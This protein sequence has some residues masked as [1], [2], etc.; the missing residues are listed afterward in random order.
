MKI[1][2]FNGLF[3]LCWVLMSC[4]AGSDQSPTATTSEGAKG[5]QTSSVTDDTQKVVQGMDQVGSAGLLELDESGNIMPSA[6]PTL[7]S[8]SMSTEGLKEEPGPVSGIMLD[9]KGRFD[10]ILMVPEGSDK[11]VHVDLH[12]AFPE[13]ADEG[14]KQ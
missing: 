9:P 10:S 12:E 6:N 5:A 1:L 8:T 11:A 3:L 2:T 4:S 13:D 14:Q 7:D